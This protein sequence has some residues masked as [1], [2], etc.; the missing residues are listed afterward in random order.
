MSGINIRVFAIE[1]LTPLMFRKPKPFGLGDLAESNLYPSPGTIAGMIRSVVWESLNRSFNPQSLAKDFKFTGVRKN[2]EIEST[3]DFEWRLI[4][5]YLQKTEGKDAGIYYPAPIGVFIREGTNDVMKPDINSMKVLSGLLNVE[6]GF[7]PDI[8]NKDV[9]NDLL[10]SKLK[11]V[12]DKFI[13]IDDLREILNNRYPQQVRLVSFDDILKS[14]EE[15]HL[16]IDRQHKILK[17]TPEGKG[18]HFTTYRI[19]LKKNWRYIFGIIPLDNTISRYFDHLNGKIAR[20]GGE[21]GYVRIH[22][23]DVELIEHDYIKR[24]LLR[25]PI[26]TSARLILTS[27]AVFLDANGYN[28][29]WPHYIHKPDYY[30]IKQVLIGGWDYVLDKP[31]TLHIGVNL[32]SVYYY[33]RMSQQIMYYDIIVERKHVAKNFRGAY[34]STLV[35]FP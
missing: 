2:K 9:L 3:Y 8:C 5:P 25:R 31:K 11:S 24:N 34:G 22:E 30:A 14:V 29:A 20:F 6:G 4:G 16:A 32:G 35:D 1:P 17:I 19:V 10:H 7:I 21:G 23:I 26:P 13:H 12:S 18:L 33:E 28:V 15:A 27:P